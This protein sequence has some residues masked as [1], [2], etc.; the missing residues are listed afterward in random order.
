MD[1]H[2]ISPPAMLSGAWRHRRLIARLVHRDVAGRYRGSWFGLGWA[3]VNPLLML[4]VYTFVFGV[5]FKA[6][7]P[8]TNGSQAEFATALFAGLIT[9]GLLAECVSRAPQLVLENPNYVK[10]IVF[11][12]EVLPWIN[13]GSA[14]FHGLLG[15][16]ILLPAI[17]VVR[18]GLPLTALAVPAI[19]LP[20][21]LLSL[22]AGWFLGALGVYVRDIG[23]IVTVAVSAL[24]FLSP[25][26]YTLESLPAPYSTW[27]SASPVAFAIEALRDAVFAGRGPDPASLLAHTLASGLLAWLGFAWF[28]KVRRGFADVL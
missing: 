4:G 1:A 2:P 28:Q 25:V 15:F 16:A 18:G 11:P 8:A 17:L 10:K 24:M 3:V 21:L 22:G 7:W 14:L 27:L 12:L 9:Y 26:F 23:Q 6:R 13:L 19:L 5:V 20:V